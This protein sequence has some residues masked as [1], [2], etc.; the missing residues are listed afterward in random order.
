MSSTTGRPAGRPGGGRYV[1]QAAIYHSDEELAALVAPFLREGAAAGEPTLLALDEARQRTVGAALGDL[2][3]VTEL[4]GRYDEPLE[5]LCASQELV[6]G[7]VDAGA[8]AVRLVGEVP[9][10][11]I[12]A[13]WDGWARY[14]AVIN[15]CY[16]SLPLWGLCCYDARTT[17]PAVLADVARVHPYVATSDGPRPNPSYLDPAVFLA[18]RARDEIDPLEAERPHVEVVDPAPATARRAVAALPAGELDPIAVD[19]LL[20]AVNEAVVNATVHGEPPVTLRAWA[21]AD[22]VVVTVHD[23]GPGVADPCT[24]LLPPAQEPTGGCGLW[25]ANRVCR[26]VTLAPDADGFT[27]RLV[28]GCPAA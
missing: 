12:A 9:H 17:P 25:L 8:A 3:G 13:N 2:A 14:E 18:E 28:A 16:A 10:A 6:T 20:L 21:A 24:G 22:R 23:H 26:R 19:G 27:V 4:G 5:T 1:H 11:G 7:H 15:R